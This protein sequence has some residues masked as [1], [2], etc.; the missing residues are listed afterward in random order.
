M[1]AAIQRTGLKRTPTTY[2]DMCDELGY[3]VS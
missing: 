2:R 1:A 3:T